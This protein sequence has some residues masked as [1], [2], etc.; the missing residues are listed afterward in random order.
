MRKKEK[1]KTEKGGSL[2]TE[3][4]SMFFWGGYQKFLF[5]GK[6]PQKFPELQTTA[7]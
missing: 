2:A 4:L 7:S 1:E 5:I 6:L 3:L